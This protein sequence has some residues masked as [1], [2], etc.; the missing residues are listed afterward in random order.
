MAEA[1]EPNQIVDQQ[2]GLLRR[3]FGWLFSLEQFHLKVLSGTAA[4]VSVILVLAAAFLWVTLRNH[5]QDGRRGRT[6]DIMRQS[7]LVENDIAALETEHR[8]F[9]LTGKPSYLSGFDERKDA[10]RKDI[11][12]LIALLTGN[13]EQHD[14]VVK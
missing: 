4:G 6:I 12:Q 9:L 7:N 13:T 8:G 3:C 2:R 5:Y 11:Q 1:E 10:V 14:L